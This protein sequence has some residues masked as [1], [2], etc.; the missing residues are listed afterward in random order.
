MKILTIRENGHGQLARFDGGPFSGVTPDAMQ[1]VRAWRRG[2]CPVVTAEGFYSSGELNGRR[3]VF[4]LRTGYASAT[5][6]GLTER[7]WPFPVFPGAKLLEGVCT[8]QG[9]RQWWEDQKG[10][11]IGF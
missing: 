2:G 1:L 5:E 10:V 6:Y 9:A 8:L 7:I 11:K 4:D 3:L